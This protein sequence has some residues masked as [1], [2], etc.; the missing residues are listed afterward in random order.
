M[1]RIL[2]HEHRWEVLVD[3][4][5]FTEYRFGDRQKPYFFPILGPDQMPMTRSWPIKTNVATEQHDH[6]HHLSLW[7]GTEVD[8][9]DCWHTTTGRIDVVD[10]QLSKAGDRFTVQT[11]WLR[12]SDDNVV[13][14]ERTNYRFGADK[15]CRW[16]DCSMEFSND[17]RDVVFKD[18]KE[19]L[20]AIRTHPDLR[21]TASPNAD[22]QSKA[23]SNIATAINSNGDVDENLWGK[24]AKWLLYR[25]KIG[26]RLAA[27]SMFDHP[28]NLRHPTTWHARD[29]G[30]IAAN[31][32]G[33]HHFLE[34]APG[35][36]DWTLRQGTKLALR[37]RI[38]FHA[39]NPTSDAA[40]QLF[41]SFAALHEI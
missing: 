10:I 13:L 19:G 30:L 9:I 39:G 29:Y 17:H 31:P 12:N 8:D 4:Q 23:N 6:P 37:Y 3:G 15:N 32:F 7:T 38:N 21:L 18:T 24:P 5:P 35:A 1:I 20:F 2:K 26:D 27:V 34:Q 25:G 41:Q 33:W 22:A 36:G 16:I 14:N 11:R 28:S 40:E